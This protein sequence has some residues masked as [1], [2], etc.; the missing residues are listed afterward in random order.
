MHRK[1]KNLVVGLFYT[2]ARPSKVEKLY[3]KLGRKKGIDMVM[4]NLSKKFNE[5]EFE[6]QIKRC[7]LIYNNAS[8]EF[9]LEPLKT[10]EEYGKKVI[11]AS[12][13][14]YYTEDKWMFHVKC[15]ENGIPTPMTILLPSNLAMARAELKEFGK[16]PV[17]IKRIYGTCGMFVEKANT[18]EEAVKIVRSIWN[19]DP[20][21]IPLIA[22]EYVK[23]DSYRVTMIDGKVVQTAIKTSNNWKHTGVFQK[24]CAK[25]RVDA[26]LR[27]I[28][29]KVFRATRINICGVDLLKKDGKWLVLEVNAEPG[30]DFFDDEMESLI[31]KILD[32][33][34]SFW[35]KHVAKKANRNKK[36]LNRKTENF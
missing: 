35:R 25:F 19:R 3:S 7:D 31:S 23:S 12:R 27:N 28:L 18:L 10:V 30:L 33:M 32:F 1:K 16:W 11:D 8:E 9:V 21:K 4:I 22:Q 17:I 29:K 24:E 36:F 15:R 20:D 14:Y 5:E 6:R 26:K 34:K 13:L 2:G